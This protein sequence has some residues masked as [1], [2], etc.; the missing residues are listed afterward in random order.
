MVAELDFKRYKQSHFYSG[1]TFSFARYLAFP[2]F[3]EKCVFVLRVTEDDEKSR[4]R[5]HNLHMFWISEI[6]DWNPRK[7][8]WFENYS[9]F[10]VNL[11]NKIPKEWT[12]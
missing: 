12:T 1:K 2:I 5:F 6:S 11:V 9:V 7:F 8:L 10:D 4:K 3:S